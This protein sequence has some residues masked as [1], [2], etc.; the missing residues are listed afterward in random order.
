MTQGLVACAGLIWHRTRDARGCV[1]DSYGT[2]HVAC[3]C[4]SWTHEA[5]SKAL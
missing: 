4:V 5:Q 3:G 1:L 2:G